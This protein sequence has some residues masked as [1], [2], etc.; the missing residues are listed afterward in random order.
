MKKKRNKKQKKQQQ[1]ARL[2]GL[3]QRQE[4]LQKHP[5]G[6]VAVR[7]VHRSKKMY[8]RKGKGGVSEV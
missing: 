4:Y 1:T 8:S 5:Q 7:K 6:Y 3:L 2:L